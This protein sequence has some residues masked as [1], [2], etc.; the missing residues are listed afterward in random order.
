LAY[1]REI[2]K[3]TEYEDPPQKEDP[4]SSW[5]SHKKTT[6]PKEKYINTLI[7]AAQKLK[8]TFPYVFFFFFFFFSFQ[9]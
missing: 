3:P 7:S 6:N 2:L 1:A 9:K 8:K 5:F 4:I